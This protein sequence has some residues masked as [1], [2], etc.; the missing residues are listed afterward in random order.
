MT[1]VVNIR[2][3][4]PGWQDDPMNV[5][6]GRRCIYHGVA[7]PESIFHNPFKMRGRRGRDACI[8]EFASYFLR[9]VKADAEFRAA[10]LALR[11]KTLVCWCAPL[12]CHGHILAA[13]ADTEGANP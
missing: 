1:T 3:L 13:Y 8:R 7:I 11:G 5:Y 9:R 2:D 6:I 12:P 10:V 4:P